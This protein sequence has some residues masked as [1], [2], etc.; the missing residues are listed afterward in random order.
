MRQCALVRPP[1]D[2]LSLISGPS[3]TSWVKFGHTLH[4]F[5]F[6]WVGCNQLVNTKFTALITEIPKYSYLSSFVA[7]LCYCSLCY[8]GDSKCIS[9]SVYLPPSSGVVYE[10]TREC[11]VHGWILDLRCL[12]NDYPLTKSLP[13]TTV[14]TQSSFICLVHSG[15][16]T[17]QKCFL[18]R[19]FVKAPLAVLQQS[20]HG[21]FQK[22]C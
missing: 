5:G 12:H 2:A 1:S 20:K 15:A 9:P 8:A 22:T 4:F 14:R 11:S 16:A 6:A 19:Y 21:N 18:V 17:F 13:A 3:V 7:V 10:C